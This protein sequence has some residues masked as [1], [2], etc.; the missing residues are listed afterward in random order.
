MNLPETI[1]NILQP[2]CFNQLSD[3]SQGHH[4]VAL[5]A[6]EVPE[7]NS[8]APTLQWLQ[9]ENWGAHEISNG[10]LGQKKNELA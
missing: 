10:R 2:I 6:Q 7:V 3:D 4:P 9:L 1:F 8:S 5:L